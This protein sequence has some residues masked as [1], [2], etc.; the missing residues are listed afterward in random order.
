MIFGQ[1]WDVPTITAPELQGVIQ[2]R[3]TPLGEYT[4]AV[5]EQNF[6]YT[7]PGVIANEVR[8]PDDDYL[9]EYAPAP[10]GSGRGA[11]GTLKRSDV[12]VMS[13][14][15]FKASPYYRDGIPFDGRMTVARAKAK[16]EIYDENNYNS[17]LRQ[18][19]AWGVGTVAALVAG[20]VIGSAPDP[21]NY[22]PTFGPAFKAANASRIAT[23]MA[24]A[25]MGAVENMAITAA[26]SPLIAQSRRQFGEDITFADQL[27][28]IALA[29][30]FGAGVGGVAGKFQR[31][32]DFTPDRV[33]TALQALG[34]AADSLANDRALNV[35]GAHRM[36]LLHGT[37]LSRS[38]FLPAPVRQTPMGVQAVPPQSLAKLG[39]R[40][41]TVD[42]TI[43]RM[44]AAGQQV[45]GD[46]KLVDL[47]R[48]RKTLAETARAS[49]PEEAW[50]DGVRAAVYEKSTTPAIQKARV[51]LAEI[52]NKI[53]TMSEGNLQ[54]KGGERF[55]DLKRQ[56][57]EILS[58][59]EQSLSPARR[60]QLGREL[61]A[62]DLERPTPAGPGLTERA[63]G[64]PQ[65][66]PLD[67]AGAL[68]GPD[69]ESFAQ[70]FQATAPNL[71]PRRPLPR[72]NDTV[73]PDAPITTPDRA[74]AAEASVGKPQTWADDGLKARAADHGINAETGEFEELAELKR[75]LDAKPSG[76][77]TAKGS[78]YVVHEDGTT[79]RNKAARDTPGHEGDSGAKART[80]K[81]VYTEGR[82]LLSAAGLSGIGPKGARLAIK[83]GKATLLMW[84]EQAGRW[85]AA[86]DQRD[87]PVFDEPAIG[88]QPLELW[89][90]KDDVPGY[91]AYSRQHA[92]N[93]IT[94]LHQ[95]GG[96]S[97]DERADLKEADAL[98]ARTDDY[99]K[100]FKAAA[101][102]MGRP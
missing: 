16:A 65:G 17:W 46:V 100:A 74:A 88:R 3:P 14:D 70:A 12:P 73:A 28:D 61:L 15:D 35:G 4:G 95:S 76:Y 90:K 10:L 59:A 32:P 94:E 72:S 54:S 92:G 51:A 86:P 84:N 93:E 52:E 82:V 20:S 7:T 9:P 87:I 36:A 80:E 89:G 96:L 83:D 34:E 67:E 31:L 98:V 55:V 21:I 29:G 62:R 49:V 33:S 23:V 64:E 37:S 71:T 42:A 18:N 48:E 39:E 78:T 58:K 77:K 6:G 41:A 5:I 81:T 60:E 50:A 19:R 1:T 99:A 43:A 75:L 68:R 85:G 57:L 30:A 22:I 66:R 91:E 11:L 69:T 24:R 26:V 2:N 8:L 40:V 38:D 102:C 97:A 101:A 79:T 47:Y 13:E 53:E 45:S 25:G 27:I 56:R 44:E 63:P